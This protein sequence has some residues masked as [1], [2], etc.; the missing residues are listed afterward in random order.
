MALHP[1]DLTS[2]LGLFAK[3][4]CQ[5][6][7]WPRMAALWVLEA[8]SDPSPTFLRVGAPYFSLPGR[9]DEVGDWKEEAGMLPGGLKEDV[10]SQRVALEGSGAAE[11]MAQVPESPPSPIPPS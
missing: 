10:R 2:P 3:G 8:V 4:Q 7:G 9:G 6:P 1:S 5:A 11:E